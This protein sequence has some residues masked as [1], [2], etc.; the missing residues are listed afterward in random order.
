[1]GAGWL[2]GLVVLSLVS[3]W[4]W[5]SFGPGGLLGAVCRLGLVVFLGPNG[6]VGERKHFRPRCLLGLVVLWAWL[7]F[8][9]GG[10]LS[11]AG[12]LGFVVFWPWS[13][14]G[15]G[16]PL[17]LMS[18]GPGCLLGAWWCFG[19]LSVS[20]SNESSQDRRIRAPANEQRKHMHKESQTCEGDRR[21]PTTCGRLKRHWTMLLKPTN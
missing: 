9:P 2:L 18:F 10:L 17:G 21:R 6:P 19:L 5:W 15:P 20:S 4:A 12:L 16:C 13:S 3:F 1:M 14:F 7:S 8:G 11:E